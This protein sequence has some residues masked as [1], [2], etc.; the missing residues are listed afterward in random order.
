MHLT[1]FLKEK[2]KMFHSSDLP[3]LLTEMNGCL[4]HKKNLQTVFIMGEYCF[5]SCIQDSMMKKQMW[6]NW[7]GRYP[8]QRTRV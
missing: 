2:Y 1:S 5:L 3:N 4:E 6:T 8:Q 7:K